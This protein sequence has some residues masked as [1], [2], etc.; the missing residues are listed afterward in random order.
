[1]IHAASLIIKNIT[2]ALMRNN[3]VRNCSVFS[4]V[5]NYPTVSD[6][7]SLKMLF[8]RQTVP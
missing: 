7:F 2:A 5:E 1:M 8:W 4:Q 3:M 6:D